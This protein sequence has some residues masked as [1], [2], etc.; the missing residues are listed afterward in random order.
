MKTIQT[1]FFLA[2]AVL[3]VS[4]GGGSYKKTKGGIL[5]Q[6][7]S[8]DK[9][10]VIKNGEFFE[11]QIGQ[12]IYKTGKKD[13]TLSDPNVVPPNQVVP[14]DST[15]LP[16]DFYT[17]FKQ[18]RKG[19]SIIVRQSTD[20]II[21]SSM[22]NVAPFLKK[23]GFI[24]T[25]YKI[26]NIFKTKT[27]ADS[28]GM[29]LM[30]QQ[31]Q[32]DSVN[33]IAQLVK[34]DQVIKDFLAKNNITAVKTEKGCYVQILEPGAGAKPDSGKQ[35]SVMYNGLTFDGKKFDSNIDTSFKHTDPLQFTIGQL[36][37][38]AGFEDGVKQIAK[39]GKAKIFVPSS[40]AYGAQGNP[41]AIKPNEN[42]I[43]EVELI[44]ISAAPKQTMPTLPPQSQGGNQ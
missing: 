44:N 30:M 27:A 10:D 2:V 31:R 14:M 36:G 13:T 41:P 26:L 7:V 15:S 42:L 39:G 23:G 32:K 5:Y 25:T 19:D 11:I 3:F 21:K 35:V 40:L 43:F 22:G 17:I 9:G 1:I 37:M 33:R 28:A 20:S 18:I 34:D 8:G 16:P 12:T 29:A 4:C 38:I 6:I 24:V